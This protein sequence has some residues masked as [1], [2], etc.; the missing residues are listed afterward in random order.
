VVVVSV[1]VKQRESLKQLK[2]IELIEKPNNLCL[3]LSQSSKTEVKF[4]KQDQNKPAIS[5]FCPTY[6]LKSLV[7]KDRELGNFPTSSVKRICQAN[8]KN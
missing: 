3:F 7:G 2:R 1:L 4:A 8:T 5:A 6:Q